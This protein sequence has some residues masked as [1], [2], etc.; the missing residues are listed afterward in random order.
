LC[1][2]EASFENSC[3]GIIRVLI[4][5]ESKTKNFVYLRRAKNLRPD[6]VE[7]GDSNT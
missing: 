5:C 7:I 2:Y 6:Q 3:G 4:H 1:L